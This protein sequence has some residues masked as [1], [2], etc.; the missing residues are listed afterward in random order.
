MIVHCHPARSRLPRLSDTVLPVLLYGQAD[1]S[2]VGSAGATAEERVRRTGIVLPQRAQ[3][4]LTI[5]LAVTTA[6]LQVVRSISPDGWT[7]E[8]DMVIGVREPD[9]WN[10]QA[11]HLASMLRFLTTDIWSFQFVLSRRRPRATRR[12]RTYHEDA[13]SLLSGGLDS[14]IG[15]LD[16]TDRGTRLLVASQIVHGDGDRQRAFAR[17]IG[18]GLTRLALNHNARGPY[19]TERSQRARS[20]AFLTYGVIG[21]CALNS[22]RADR[23]VYLYVCENGLIALNPPLTE[24]RTGS[25]STRTAHPRYLAD[26]QQLLQSM[27]FPIVIKNPYALKT[28][29]EMLRECPKQ[30]FLKAHAHQSTSCGR[31]RTHR[32]THCGRCIPCIIRRAAFKAWRQTDLTEYVFANL[33]RRDRD[34]A[35]YDDVR[36]AK[37][38]VARL[39]EDG[40]DALLGTTLLCDAIQD[41]QPYREVVERGMREIARLLQSLKVR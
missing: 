40:I 17:N 5:A 29:G 12:R 23:E 25:R 30:D 41:P 6:D 9:F 3:D 28:K 8:L 16:L 1:S 2:E 7:R 21:A 22:F 20:F 36:A 27:G 38:G 14:L 13:V 18:D 33:G 37:L 32:L 24:L 15:A 11:V 26:F 31:F 19:Y 39:D 34:H 35:G 10:S 4:L